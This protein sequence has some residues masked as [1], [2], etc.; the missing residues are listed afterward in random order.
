MRI[1]TNV[2]D[3]SRPT[4]RYL[5]II[6]LIGISLN[7][8]AQ[9]TRL[10]G[11][12]VDE[13]NLPMPGVS[14]KVKGSTQGIITGDDG[15]YVLNATSSTGV[16]EFSFLGY[17]TQEKSFNGAQTIDMKMVPTQNDLNEV[18][19][20]GYGT[21]RRASVVGAVDQITSAAIEGK[22]APNLITA[23]Q[24]VSPNLTIQQRSNEPGQPLNIN[25]RGV[26]TMGDN[27]PLVVIDGLVGGDI[28][29]L[30]PN[31]VESISVLK[32]AGAA[33]I[34][35]SRSANGVLLITTKK[36]S[37]NAKSSI[38]YNGLVGVQMPK[39]FWKPVPG[40]LNAILRNEAN[41]NAGQL[42]VY[43]PEQIRNFQQQGDNE[44]FLD[45]IL[46]DALQQNHNI[47][48]SGGSDKSSYLVSA[49][50]LDQRS[51]LVGQNFGLK[52]YNYRLNMTNEY[53]RLKLTSILAY[54]KS[55]ILDHSS[56]T[57]TLIVDASR[58]PLYY[59]LKDDQGRYL[60]NDVLS[61]FNPLGQL[62]A[63]GYRK[64]NN[65]NLFGNLNA[66]L[67]VT[68]FLKL[69]GVVGGT[70]N[71]NHQYARTL[72]VNYFPSG[73]SG[74]D[75]NTNDDNFKD[76][77]INTQLL[78][79]FSKTFY[80]KHIVSAMVGVTSE[81]YKSESNAIYRKFTDPELGTPI[82][83]T[84]IDPGSANSNQ[85]TNE[86]SLQSVLGR[87][88]YS[89]NDI[90]YG[91]FSFRLDASS[92]FSKQNRSAF[93]PSF[94]AGYRLSQE[95]FM[96]DYRNKV[97]DLKIR[98]SYGILGNQ[99]VG[100]YQYQTTYFYYNNA[101]GFNNTAV[102]GTGINFANNN[103]RWEKAAILNL[104]IDASFLKNALTVSLDYFNKKTTDILIPPIVPGAF[105]SGLP[106]YNAGEMKN[107]GW[108]ANVNYRISGEVFKHT[109]GINL[110]DSKN[111]VLKIDGG[112]QFNNSDEMT[113]ITQVGLPFHSYV[114]LKRDGYFQTPEQAATG[115]KPTGL[116]VG[117]GDIRF[118]DVNGDNVI[119]DRDR[120]VLGNP[121]PRYTFGLNYNLQV[122]GFDLGIFI[123]GVGRRSAF[124]RGELIEPFHFNY[125]QTVY[126]N[127]LDY[128]TPTNPNAAYPRLAANGSVSNTN[129]FRRGSDLYLF[130][131]AYARLKNVQLGYTLPGG[132]AKKL[133]MQKCRAYFSG[134][135][136]FTLSKLDFLDPEATEFN[137]N[138]QSGGANSG[139][140]YPTP[141]Y[142]GFG[143]DVTF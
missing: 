26:S 132:V 136:L 71:S 105:G 111:K 93:F 27:S 58:V 118:V 70:L 30:N 80:Q 120:H 61:E 106:T 112:T 140:S 142:V 8:Y 31:D 78:A 77:L 64:Y 13:K 92:K 114:G 75:R 59:K 127:S 16:L 83:E 87:A 134:T 6:F 17:T 57:S 138:L 115:P 10:Q 29:L 122:K 119:D 7:S 47:S 108:E 90:Y 113:Y 54:A 88:N 52:R 130:D 82:T 41:V 50:F 85:R 32:D 45:G 84:I 125:G 72:R 96:Q 81:A 110:A 73:V 4:L 89:Y 68:D 44:Y 14:I 107:E 126:K 129:N 56:S 79:E 63:G 137:S 46:K 121:F 91:E 100:N 12:V 22:P 128:W 133:G 42:P 97:G 55:D 35:G 98:G 143:L 21:Q 67:K 39:I 101:Y 36:G 135:N 38:N 43:T 74:A 69:R 99:N 94:S 19:V 86:T 60:T 1:F 24:G 5:F 51:N 15:K 76:L 65:D 18:V 103:L 49:G 48:L 2:K 11:S 40:Y 104:G 123:Q 3:L 124:V 116:N 34:Y 20:V 62:E 53:G 131:A 23:L 37:K 66:E 9:S 139:R 102:N 25:I 33:A 28:N 141:V 117:P 109:I 95:S